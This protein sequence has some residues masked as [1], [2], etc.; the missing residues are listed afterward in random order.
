METKNPKNKQMLKTYAKKPKF[1]NKTDK[2]LVQKQETQLWETWVH[3]SFT[4]G[5]DT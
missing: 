5:S 2:K 1:Q 4:I 3:V